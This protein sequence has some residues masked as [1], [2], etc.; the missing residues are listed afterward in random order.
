MEDTMRKAY[1]SD[2]K[3]YQWDQIEMILP[4]K[5][6][7]GRP[8]EVNYRE[9]INAFAYLWKVECAWRFLP[10]DFPNRSTVRKYYDAWHNA[11]LL[12]CIKRIVTEK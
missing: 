3:D 9:I 5:P 12:E 7:M 10:N 4:D 2:I 1:P 8:V 11:G 6:E